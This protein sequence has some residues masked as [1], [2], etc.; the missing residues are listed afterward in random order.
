[1]GVPTNYKSVINDFALDEDNK[2]LNQQFILYDHMDDVRTH[3][4]NV[5]SNNKDLV[6]IMNQLST[7]GGTGGNIDSDDRSNYITI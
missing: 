2:A 5:L 1:M 3:T 7:S 4:D 6:D